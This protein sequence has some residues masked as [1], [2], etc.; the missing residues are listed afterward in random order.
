[1][2]ISYPMTEVD[3][4]D[5]FDEFKELEDLQLTNLQRGRLNEKKN[6]DYNDEELENLYCV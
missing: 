1:M 5:N 6:D 2:D 3:E 4:E